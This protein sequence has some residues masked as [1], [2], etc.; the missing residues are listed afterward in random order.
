M[1]KKLIKS[2]L[3][4]QGYFVYNAENL[5]YGCDHKEDVA[6][7]SPRLN[8]NTIFDVGANIGS[9]TLAYRKRF[10]DSRLYSFEPVNET[11]HKLKEA[12]K[13]DSKIHCYNMA[14]AARSG[15]ATINI[16]SKSGQNSLVVRQ[17]GEVSSQEVRL[18]TLDDFMNSQEKI[19]QIDILKI[20]VEGFERDVLKGA[21]KTLESG[22]I[23]YI[24]IETTFRE[25]DGKHTQFLQIQEILKEYKFNLMGLYDVYPYWAGGNAI[26]FCNVLFKRWEKD[27]IRLL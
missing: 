5:P 9:M 14:L 25:E 22:K 10:P 15:S 8:V 7:I 23:L 1:L 6:R 4:S 19:K 26:P 24:F 11:F 18:I 16:G 2:L 3:E 27:Y 12:T 13:H 20:D 21:E 17:Q